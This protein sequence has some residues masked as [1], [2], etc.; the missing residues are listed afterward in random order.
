MAE[1]SRLISRR[2]QVKGQI[3]RCVTFLKTPLDNVNVNMV[4]GRKEKLE[5]SW[6]DF[7]QIQAAI[8]EIENSQEHTEYE[9]E[10]ENLYFEALTLATT[11]INNKQ[12][13]AR[14]NTSQLQLD[15]GERQS[16]HQSAETSV[17]QQPSSIVKLAPLNVPVFSGNYENWTSFHDMFIAL[18]HT[19]TSLMN[20]QKFFYLRSSLEGNALQVIKSLETT[21]ENYETARKTLVDRFRNKRFLIQNH[22][23]SMFDLEPV[24]KESALKLR[25]LIDSIRGHIKALE[26]LG[27]EPKTWG[28][29][30]IHVIVIKLDAFTTK[31]WETQI[32]E[33]NDVPVVER[34]LKFLEKRVRVLEAVEASK[35]INGRQQQLKKSTS[36]FTAATMIAKCYVCK[37]SHATYK[38]PTLL[39]LS[40]SDRIKRVT[41]LKLC[42]ICLKQ[43]YNKKCN[44][45][46]CPK[47]NKSH[48]S[49]LHITF[50]SNTETTN[51]T[52]EINNSDNKDNNNE[53]CTTISAHASQISHGQIL[54]ST[55]VVRVVNKA[56]VSILC[57]A[58][59]DS[60]S[61]N[62]FIR[63]EIAQSL[64][65]KRT[66]INCS[67]IGIEGSKHVATSSIIIH[68]KS[69]V[70]DYQTDVECIV[71]P[72]LTNN[73]PVT[74]INPSSLIIPDIEFAD[75]SFATPQRIDI[76]IGACLFYEI[77]CNQQQ[78]PSING[79][80]YQKTK[81]GW[82]VSGQVN[83]NISNKN[84]VSLFSSSVQINKT[85]EEQIARFWRLEEC[86][87]QDTYTLEE[88]MCRSH[89][90]NTTT[91]GPDGRFIVQ[92]P[93]RDSSVNLS[94]SYT[95]ALRRF[96]ALEKRLSSNPQLKSD[97]TKFMREYLDLGHMEVIENI[98]INKDQNYFLP[99]HA[100]V[101]ESSLTTKLRVVFDGSCKTTSGLNL[102]DV[103]LKGPNIQQEL[104]CI[105]ARF[106]TH[107]YALSADI[108]KMNRQIWIESKH[109]RYQ[110]IIWSEEV[111]QPIKIYQLKTVTYG[112]TPASYLSTACLTKLADQEIHTY[113]VACSA[114]K[115]DYCVDDYLGGAR[116]ISDAILL[117][118]QL[119][120]V[121]KRA[122]FEL[123][124]WASNEPELLS[125]IP[126]TDNVSMQV[127][128]NEY[129]S[130]IKLLGL[131]WNTSLD[132][133]QYKVN[134]LPEDN[135]LITKRNVLS[136]IATIFDPLGLIG[137][138]VMHAKL[139][140]QS[141]WQLHLNWDESLPE[142][143]A[144]D[145]INFKSNLQHV[146]QL[147]IPRKIIKYKDVVSIQVHGFADASVKAYGACIYIRSVS[148][149]GECDVQLLCA[150]SRVAPLKVISLPRLEL[151]A[152]LL[153]ARLANKFIPKLNIDVDRKYYWTDSSIALSWISSPSTKWNT[154][155][156]HRVGEIQ[157]L[158]NISEWGH[159]ATLFN[160][161]DILSRGCT[162]QQLCDDILWWN[163]PGWLK[164]KSTDWPTFDRT[165][166][167]ATNIPEQ[168]RMITAL[169][170]VTYYD[171][172][173]INRFSSLSKLI[174][175]VALIYRFIH[176]VKLHIF[177]RNTAIDRKLSGVISA[178][179]YAKARIVLIKIVQL[180]CWSHEIQ[181]IR[182]KTP[183]PR[184]SNLCQLRPYI[185]ETGILR[186]GGRLR[187]AIALNIFQRNPIL[188]PHRSVFTKLIFENEH[189]KI[190]HGGPQALLAA[191]RSTYWPIN[192]RHIARSIVH[193]CIPCFKLKPVVFQP[194]MGD[195][196]KDRVTPSRPFSKCGIDY[197]GPIMIKSGLR[198]NSP[199]VKG[200]ICV[201]VCFA[202]KAVHIELVCD[203]T[204]ESF[205]NALRRF[206]SRRGIVSDIYSD[207]ATNFVGANR[208]LLEIHDLLYSEKNRS[209][210]NSATADI[211]IKWHF[212][213]PRSPNFG[214]LWEASIKSIKYHLYRTLGNASLTYEE[215][216]TILIRIEACLNSRPITPLSTDPSDLSYLTPGHFLIGD[217]LI[218]IPEPDLNNTPMNRLNRWQQISRLTQQIW[219]HW[220]KQY[221]NQLQEIKKWKQ[222][223][224]RSI[225]VGT[226]VIIREDNL[227]PLQWRMA[228]VKEV[229]QGSDGEIRVATVAGQGWECK[230]SIRKLCPLPFDDN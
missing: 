15:N 212:I 106:R 125:N 161:A 36:I 203:L 45:R 67:V 93:F 190:M 64:G 185:D 7:R 138:V 188:L 192:G 38:C 226:V 69:R 51:D 44:M 40:I 119:I 196:P 31:E 120:N 154:F 115:T 195:L 83:K 39:A 62:N 74:P 16:S 75:P 89:F 97:Y 123:R 225:K 128:D 17:S 72:K 199:L 210:L 143:Y 20:V 117:R 41:E 168:R 184:K 133:F 104:V 43:H 214:G 121:L 110:M 107:H 183:I 227:P 156:S 94:D 76:I 116:T 213:P 46:N 33:T 57:R 3:T 157:D 91:R 23:K 201:F 25:Q 139:I 140:M 193:K 166:F 144:S 71:L 180:Q 197:A 81:L 164:S 169:P 18:I 105:L 4:I 202:T 88:K 5:E 60:G 82:V 29:L 126:N 27:Q 177:D 90:E 35:H 229:H 221:L 171:N 85:I 73:I 34:L 42:K 132:V 170:S 162:P 223:K 208:R 12:Y 198:R 179:E 165:N 159:V 145:W 209:M 96:F 19:N 6:Q 211:G 98:D 174:R 124:K 129:D 114:I 147:K 173:I 21:S 2:G 217:S 56:G 49:L 181:C 108:T 153:L 11:F 9:Y 103:L 205:L 182:D 146:N 53:P 216:N 136:T 175:V 152:V 176:N 78:R 130:V 47:C 219:S 79:P 189:R 80:I 77:I 151:C 24:Y 22:I 59:L 37:L 13:N 99:H 95:T 112:T 160:P 150:K 86:Y 102:N 8:I 178:E 70:S 65:I 163:G 224:G 30:L 101:K 134:E 66:P 10:V 84:C 149:T 54:L 142:T 50:N 172:F 52:A 158:T 61:E 204:T 131:Y 14:Q 220:S 87:T 194:I 32:S 100:V 187:N 137:P 228:R 1:L 111:N 68:L 206:V 113:S 58:L 218:A 191:V 109:R 141:L 63:E 215:L 155:V 127:L 122:G 186:V 26:S 230:R 207:N 48:N 167:A 118:D 28:C 135:T 148:S 55:A 222:N 200:Y 92:L